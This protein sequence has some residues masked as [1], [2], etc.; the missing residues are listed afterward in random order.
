MRTAC[1]EADVIGDRFE[2]VSY[3][4]FGEATRT[5]GVELALYAVAK[6]MR[7]WDGMALEQDLRALAESPALDAARARRGRADG[8][9]RGPRAE[10]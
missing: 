3:S 7:E 8:T 9:P 1:L 4:S 10:A 2:R 6:A 5:T